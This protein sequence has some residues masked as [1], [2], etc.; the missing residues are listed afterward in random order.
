M[1]EKLAPRARL[2]IP[3]PVTSPPI[4][5]SPPLALQLDAK[6]P[7]VEGGAKL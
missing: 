6:E 1:W 3:T 7:R 5:L 4:G 2:P